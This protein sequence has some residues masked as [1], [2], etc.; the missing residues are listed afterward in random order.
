MHTKLL[1]KKRDEYVEVCVYCLRHGAKFRESP[2]ARNGGCTL[3]RT[4]R[5]NWF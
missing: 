1:F 3:I 4:M 5:H 2:A